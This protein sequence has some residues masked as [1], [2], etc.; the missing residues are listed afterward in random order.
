[1]PVRS[2]FDGA[3]ADEPR[4][5]RKRSNP[6]ALKVARSMFLPLDLVAIVAGLEPGEYST[7]QPVPA[8]Q[9]GITAGDAGSPPHI[10]A[11]YLPEPSSVG[12]EGFP[13]IIGSRPRWS[14]R[15]R[16]SLMTRMLTVSILLLFPLLAPAQD[17]MNYSRLEL[18]V[19]QLQR[20]VL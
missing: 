11:A 7:L 17:G 8:L 3:D 10:E 5:E 15:I 1:M 12:A 18:D 13:W 16:R 14:G 4:P 20:E 9:F 19:R 2:G 6:S